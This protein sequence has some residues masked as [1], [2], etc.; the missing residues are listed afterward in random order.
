MRR[1]FLLVT[2]CVHLREV[3]PYNKQRN[4]KQ[5]EKI[6]LKEKQSTRIYDISAEMLQKNLSLP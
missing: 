4:T 3:V 5:A 2:T 6:E 1:L